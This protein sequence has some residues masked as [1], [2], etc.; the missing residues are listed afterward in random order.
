MRS[1]LSAALVMRSPIPAIL[2][3]SLA[4]C[5]EPISA[6]PRFDAETLRFIKQDY[7]QC[8]AQCRAEGATD[9]DCTAD[10]S[11]NAPSCT[12]QNL[13]CLARCR[14]PDPPAL[15]SPIVQIPDRNL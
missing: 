5:V 10:D 11:A 3:L 12:R 13:A 8:R 9:A 15:Q 2:L 7:A 6:T 1:S 14:P 4:G